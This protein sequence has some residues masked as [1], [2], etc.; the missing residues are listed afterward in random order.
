MNL[1]IEEV[2]HVAK[3]TALELSEQELEKMKLDLNNILNFVNTLEELDTRNVL[4]T[5][6]VHGAINAFREDIVRESFDQETALQNAA[7][8]KDSFFRVPKII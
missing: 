6:H 1:S 3:L 8:K 5:S 4:P 7:D 2:R